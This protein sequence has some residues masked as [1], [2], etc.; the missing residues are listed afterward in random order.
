MM[1]VSV[2]TEPEFT[3]SKPSLLFEGDFLMGFVDQTANYDVAPDGERF[4]ML[5]SIEGMR[6]YEIA[7]VLNWFEELKRLVP[8]DN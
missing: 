4:V 6:G 3:P 5:Q 1:R 8:T 7:V 2:S